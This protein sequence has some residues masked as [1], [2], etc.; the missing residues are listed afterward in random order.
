[1][2]LANEILE[3]Y[4]DDLARLAQLQNAQDKGLAERHR[5]RLQNDE[6]VVRRGLVWRLSCEQ[7]LTQTEI[8]EILGT[9]QPTIS[10]DLKAIIDAAL[11][12]LKEQA[13][14]EK[15]LQIEQLRHMISALMSAWE[16]SKETEKS[17]T[18]TTHGDSG[19]GATATRIRSR[20]GD[21]T[22]LAEA[23]ACM[24]DIRDILGTDAPL[25]F[26][27]TTPD[28]KEGVTGV[29]IMLPDNNRGDT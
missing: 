8:A 26:A 1:L 15:I 4:E 17:V 13:Q 2:L 7:A 18:Q 11:E 22:Y 12:D 19:N 5:R 6:R 28:G 10:R 14:R 21:R 27:Q 20:E 25:K 24:K 3:I 23:R 29:I 16:A 9:S